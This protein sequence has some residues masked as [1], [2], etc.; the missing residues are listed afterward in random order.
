MSRP[1]IPESSS[2]GPDA[3]PA[4]GLRAAISLTASFDERMLMERIAKRYTIPLEERKLPSDDEVA[5]TVSERVTS[6]LEAK[7]RGRDNLQ[8]ERMRRFRPLIDEWMESDEG[9]TLLAMLVDDFY[10][11]SLHARPR[12]PKKG[13]PNA[14][15]GQGTQKTSQWPHPPAPAIAAIEETL[16]RISEVPPSLHAES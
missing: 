8:T 5:A 11:E 6:L 10:Q 1:K 7:L 13:P 2:T 12:C 4:P 16:S 15:P 9:Q 3:P 14:P